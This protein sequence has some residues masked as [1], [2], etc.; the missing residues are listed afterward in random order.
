ME[1]GN[2]L[3]KVRTLFGELCSEVF[4]LVA[5]GNKTPQSSSLTKMQF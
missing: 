4:D 2:D 1:S 3:V 5:T